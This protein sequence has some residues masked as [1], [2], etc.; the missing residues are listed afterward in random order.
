MPFY[1]INQQENTGSFVLTTNVW[2]VS[3]IYNLNNVDDDF[4]ELL[5]RLYQNLNLIAQVL[6][7]KD[8]AYYLTQEFNTGQLYFNSTSTDPMML[9]PGFRKV[10]NTGALTAGVNTIAHNINGATGI[11][12]NY[13]WFFINGAATNSTT[14][15]GVPLPYAGIAG[16]DN[17]TVVVNKFNLVITNNSGFT[18]DKSSVTLEYVQN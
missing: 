5:V 18:F 17:I 12:S 8:S 16:N 11:T 3:E 4:K 13:T 10:I 15:L 14:P 2:D 1:P 7:S 6:N 9:K